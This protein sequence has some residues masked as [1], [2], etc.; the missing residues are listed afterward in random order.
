MP[1]RGPPVKVRQQ[2]AGMSS[3]KASGLGEGVDGGL[4]TVGLSVALSGD[5]V[6]A[7]TGACVAATGA[8]VVATTGACVAATGAAVVATTGA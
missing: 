6:V 4:L 5:Y 8:D 1:V 3:T 7:T 2:T